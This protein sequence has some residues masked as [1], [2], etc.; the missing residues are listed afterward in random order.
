[1]GY[2]QHCMVS[3]N[4][5][6]YR[7]LRSLASTVHFIAT[8]LTAVFQV[9]TGNSLQLNKINVSHRDIVAQLHHSVF[10][11][12]SISAKDYIVSVFRLPLQSRIEL[13]SSVSL[14]SE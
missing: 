11:F 14:R 8:V 12:L 4:G 10:A 5:L 13:R 2:R 3:S 1:M 9:P 6:S 7:P